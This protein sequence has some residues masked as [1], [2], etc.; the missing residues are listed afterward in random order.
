MNTKGI[1]FLAVLAVMVMAFAAI[2]ALA[3]ADKDV[4]AIEVYGNDD[5]KVD[6]TVIDVDTAYDKFYI[7]NDAVVKIKGLPGDVEFYVQNGMELELNIKAAISDKITIYS[8]TADQQRP[9]TSKV[10]GVDT[11]PKVTDGKIRIIDSKVVF[12]GN[13]EQTSQTVVYTAMMPYSVVTYTTSGKA[14]ATDVSTGTKEYAQKYASI[15]ADGVLYGVTISKYVTVASGQSI[16]TDGEV[17]V[18]YGIMTYIGGEYTY[19]AKGMNAGSEELASGDYVTIKKGTIAVNTESNTSSIKA[20]S[21]SGGVTLTGT[22]SKAIE[23]SKTLSAG[24]LSVSGDVIFKDLTNKATVTLNGTANVVSDSVVNIDVKG[25]LILKND[26]DK[27]AK[28]TVKGEGMI[29][30]EN[31]KLWFYPETDPTK[32]ILNFANTDETTG[33]TAGFTGQFDVYSITKVADV[34]EA[35][36]TAVIEKNQTFKVVA[37]TVVTTSLDIQGVLIIEPGV[38][39]TITKTNAVGAAVTTTGQYAQIINYGEIL[40]KTTIGT[41]KE[42]KITESGLHIHGGYVLNE[43]KIVA[44]SDAK[45]KD[46]ITLCVKSDVGMGFVNNGVITVSKNDNVELDDNFTNAANG[47]VSINGT[48]NS[49]GTESLVNAGAF[50]L[51]NAKVNSLS[52]QMKFGATFNAVAVEVTEGSSLEVLG[53]DYESSIK[54]AA[55]D[56]PAGKYTVRGFTVTD[57]E[58]L[59]LAG[60]IA[61]T[62]PTVE[63]TAT[64]PKA[65]MTL[66]GSVSVLTTATIA[67][68]YNIDFDACELSVVGTLT[69]SKGVQTINAAADLK[70]DLRMFVA[71]TTICVEKDIINGCTYVAAKYS[72]ANGTTIYTTLADAVAGAAI[73]EVNIIEVGSDLTLDEEKYV[74]VDEDLVIPAGMTVTG[75]EDAYLIVDNKAK[76]LVEATARLSIDNVI[77]ED[78]VI[79]A[80]DAND[81]D[82]DGIVADVKQTDDE[83]TAGACMSLEYA[84]ANASAGQVIELSNDFFAADITLEI[85]AGVTVDATAGDDNT[86]FVLV[87]SNLIVNGVLKVNQF[88][89]IAT[90]DDKI[91]ITLNGYIYDE[92]TNGSCFAP[93]WYVPFGVSSN[94]TDENDKI[95]YVLT[96]IEHIQDAIDQADDAKVAVEGDAKLDELNVHGRDD[97]PAEVTFKGNVDIKVINIDDTTL[98]FTE[99]KKI[100]TTVKDALGSITITGAY[101][102]AKLSIYSMDDAGVYMAGVVTDNED[103]TYSI[104]FD[105][106][107]GMNGTS[108]TAIAW[109]EYDEATPTIVFAGETLATG[110]K[111]YINEDDEKSSGM[112]TII[113]SLVANNG[114]KI[115]INSDAQVLGAL[116]ALDRTEDAVAGS[117]EM[118]GDLF[119]G[120]L[121][122]DVYNS[123]DAKAA[124]EKNLPSVELEESADYGQ[125]WQVTSAAAVISGNIELVKV[126]APEKPFFITVLNGS[127]VDPQIIEDLDSMNVLIEGEVWITVYGYGDSLYSM[128]GLKAPIVN[129][130]VDKIVDSDGNEIADFDFVYKVIYNCS[131]AQLSTYGDVS[132]S[133]DYNVFN[134]LI[135]TDGSV[136]AVYI[137]GILMYT[138]ENRNTF[139]LDKVAT[140]THKVTVEASAGYDADKCVLYTDMG[141]I[142][143][144]MAFTFTEYD[145]KLIDDEYVVIYNINGTEIQPE[146]VPPTPE[147]E[148]QW[149]ITTILLVI[150][151]VLIAIMAVIVALRLN[152]S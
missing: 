23:V 8:V 80:E 135:K 21:A 149:T 24:T 73:A 140:G 129:A 29:T 58:G 119:V 44:T 147:E 36:S 106:I 9:T 64:E 22:S 37:D 145:C 49:V 14:I 133:L 84:L 110:K 131:D 74:T 76:I 117:I 139:E 114:T 47:S 39:L 99:G 100:T 121:K 6:P 70:D 111:V 79:A 13:T 107:T 93:W 2:V 63:P 45:T 123:E 7:S 72:L 103:G 75:V 3:P 16:Q 142:L 126:D 97:M 125:S 65:T 86:D 60:N 4:T 115:I 101:A 69:L 40:I 98:K 19:Y 18:D 68:G 48:L 62:V 43:G 17:D 124:Y 61:I 127:E 85:P 71:G 55:P 96:N 92:C 120:A 51:N 143:P 83:S 42:G 54:I 152:R 95:W 91:G 34:K 146:P 109:G 89:F 108:R 32:P 150:L 130:A 151:V 15:S 57:I 31:E 41:E 137:D 27:V 81:I 132:I 10:D 77:V 11:D 35:F 144:G 122:T 112:A 118:N 66:K 90:T 12:S 50:T 148:S 128:D 88:K 26:K 141:T 1:K 113:G 105:G 33:E 28:L 5:V 38:T 20:T 134:V 87:N 59:D 102:G 67:S 53:S 104:R 78:G 25:N 138:G 30:A 46:A 56:T 116:I 52:V 136:K 94:W 82:M